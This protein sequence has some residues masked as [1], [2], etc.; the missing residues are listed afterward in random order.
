IVIGCLVL[1]FLNLPVGKTAADGKTRWWWDILKEPHNSTPAVLLFFVLFAGLMILVMGAA[2]R[3]LV[4]AWTMVGVSG[5]SFV[6]FLVVGLTAAETDG[7]YFFSLI[8][9]YLAAGLVG[10]CYFRSRAP[11]E[12]LGTIF[13]GVF[14]GL[15]LF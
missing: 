11:Q 14:G 15:L 9:P 8:I 4:R 7:G 10:L 5:L 2:T 13:Q 1:L 12:K 3:G 6:L